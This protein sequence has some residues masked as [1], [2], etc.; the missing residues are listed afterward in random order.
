M[1]SIGQIFLVYSDK[2]EDY[3]IGKGRFSFTKN[4]DSFIVNFWI[5]AEY[6][7]MMPDGQ[8]DIVWGPT[9]EILTTHNSLLEIG[10]T[11]KLHILDKEK[12]GKEWDINYRTGFYHQSHQMIK[13]CDIHI[14]KLNDQQIDVEFKGE[15]SDDFEHF[16]FKGKCI[17]PISDK[18]E[19]YW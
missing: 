6:E 2:V 9:L 16:T 18:I 12:A 15:P 11:S 13:D 10:E 4:D 7:I 5:R 14:K 8:K 17:L 1:D 19:R 3:R